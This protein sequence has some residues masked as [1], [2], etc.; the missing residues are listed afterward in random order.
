MISIKSF[1][2]GKYWVAVLLFTIGGL[3][4]AHASEVTQKPPMEAQ[5]TDLMV[6]ATVKLRPAPGTENL[7]TNGVGTTNLSAPVAPIVGM[8]VTPPTA[9]SNTPARTSESHS[10]S[11]ASSTEPK[12][13][14]ISKLKGDLETAR[15]LRSTRQ[16]KSAMPMLVKL[17]A[18][19]V[20]EP[21][22]RDAL[23]ELGY[24]AQDE[25]DL[26][27]AQTV[28]SQFIARWPNESRAPE[29]LL[30]QGQLFRQMGL[31]NLALAK[32]YSVMTAALALKN[33]QMEFYQQLVLKAQTEIAESNYQI[34]KYAE[35]ADFFARLLK[36]NDPALDRPQIQFRLI[37]SLGSLARS[38]ETAGQAE[39][40]LNRYAEAPQYPEVRFLLAQA[41]KQMGRNNEALQHVLVLLREQKSRTTNQPEVWAYW[42]Q[43]A[44][45]EIANQLYR[46]GDYAKALD[47]YLNL[48]ELDSSP[49]WQ[50]P[51]T[52]QVGM[53]FERLQ[54]PE[55]AGESYAKI[56]ARAPEV[57]TN[58]SP[59]L[60]AVLDMARWR[61]DFLKWQGKAQTA[62]LNIA[63]P[64][65]PEQT[66][67]NAAPAKIA[68]Q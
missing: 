30:R 20:P 24:G 42:Q 18:D 65:P 13:E 17:L 32:F 49:A 11:S 31:N 55:K 62:N 39:D 35:A 19:G 16:A 40:F 52:Y 28:F 2:L 25:N 46:E 15:F 68:R 5:P 26:A 33:D 45:N 56:V 41:L 3:W 37:R 29:I 43:R 21:I 63:N 48:G 61:M 12:A 59:G 14:I 64:P 67:T 6:A 1:C 4:F 27:R 36:Q 7:G 53:T 54:Q 51:V 10:Q 38:E 47:V 57:S 9:K 8:P 66:A 34:G 23:L 50:I 22:Q 44:G 60:K 58:S